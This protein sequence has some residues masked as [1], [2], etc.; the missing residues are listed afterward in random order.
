MLS[1]RF[2]S[3]L[4]HIYTSNYLVA[5][6]FCLLLHA[7]KDCKQNSLILNI[8]YN[9]VHYNHNKSISSTL[10]RSYSTI[11]GTVTYKVHKAQ[12]LP[13]LLSVDASLLGGNHDLCIY[14]V[15]R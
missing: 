3:R 4:P 6:F 5:H 13:N 7:I 8:H 11:W 14:E 2:I 10:A 12:Y 1:F 9:D 15:F